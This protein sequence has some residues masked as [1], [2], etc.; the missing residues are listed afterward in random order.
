M[1]LLE[2]HQKD[3]GH[4]ETLWR[5]HVELMAALQPKKLLGPVQE[6]RGL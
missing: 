2:H 5:A 3:G 4:L 1:F 6:D